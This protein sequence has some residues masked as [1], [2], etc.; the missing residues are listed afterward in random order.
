MTQ[1]ERDR[2]LDL[3]GLLAPTSTVIVT[4]ALDAM[5]TGQTLRILT[6]DTGTGEAISALFL[7]YEDADVERN[8]R[9]GLVELVI[10]T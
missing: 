10:R 7:R 1:A 2:V 3:R 6:N 9:D 5:K 8:E 4:K